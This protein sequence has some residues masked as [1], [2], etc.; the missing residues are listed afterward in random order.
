[1]FRK[2]LALALPPNQKNQLRTGSQANYVLAFDGFRA[3]KWDY[4]VYSIPMACAVGK[5]HSTNL[6]SIY[7]PQYPGPL[8]HLVATT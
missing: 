1:M 8:G 7:C 6:L 5:Q 3:E 4:I 2:P